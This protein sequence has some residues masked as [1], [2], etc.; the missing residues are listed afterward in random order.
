MTS[1]SKLI[2]FDRSYLNIDKAGSK[3]IEF[4]Y[5]IGLRWNCK[6]CGNCCK[7]PKDRARRILLLNSDIERI[8]SN[9]DIET[10]YKEIFEEEPFIAEMLKRKGSCIFLNAKECSIYDQRALLCRMYPFYIE[11]KEGVFVIR[12]DKSCSGINI[13]E[14]LTLDFYKKI[15]V[16]GIRLREAL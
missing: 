9:V 14:P 6:R 1:Y 15:L 8:I 10:F 7:D 12:Y 16:E 5:P 11:S 2:L 3:K 4:L 13:G